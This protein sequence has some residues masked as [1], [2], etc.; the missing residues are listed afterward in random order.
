MLGFP[1]VAS[2]GQ[3]YNALVMVG[4]AQEL[5]FHRKKHLYETDETWAVE[6]QDW[7]IFEVCVALLESHGQHWAYLTFRHFSI[8]SL[9]STGWCVRSFCMGLDV[10]K[11]EK[12]RGL[13]TPDPH[14]PRHLHGPQPLALR[15]ALRE[16]ERAGSCV[17]VCW[18]RC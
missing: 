14:M 8:E 3:A 18:R 11:A 9:R 15:V 10:H 17:C 16:C 6:G 13:C 4:A 12:L 7:S 1:E 5:F 2:D